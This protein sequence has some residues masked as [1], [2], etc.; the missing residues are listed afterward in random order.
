MPARCTS[1]YLFAFIALRSC[2]MGSNYGQTIVCI[3]PVDDYLSSQAVRVP[4]ESVCRLRL[5]TR[6]RYASTRWK[7]PFH[8]IK[9]LSV[10][11]KLVS[12]FVACTDQRLNTIG[13][14]VLDRITLERHVESQRRRRILS[15]SNKDYEPALSRTG[16]G[17]HE[18]RYASHPGCCVYRVSQ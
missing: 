5:S 15:A 18:A 1:L 14:G 4:G 16:G 2:Q 6:S 12:R 17:V 13:R 10:V 7:S 3:V 8:T 11:D 9:D